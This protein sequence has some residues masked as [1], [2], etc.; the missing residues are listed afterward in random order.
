MEIN[1]LKNLISLKRLNGFGNIGILK[2]INSFPNILD[3]RINFTD[4]N[5]FLSPRLLNEF[6]NNFNKQFD[7]AG[8]LIELCQKKNIQ[9]NTFLDTNYPELLKHIP[10]APII[11]YTKGNLIPSPP[12]SIAIVGTRK[13]SE[14][15]D[16]Q[17]KR[18]TEFLAKQNYSIV[19]GLALGIDAISHITAINNNAHCI[20]VLGNGV[21]IP[22]PAINTRLY[23]KLLE[24]NGCIISEFEPGTEPRAEFF[25]SRNRIIAGLAKSTLVIEAAIKSGSLI[26][27]RQAFEY[28]RDVYALPADITRQNSQGCNL[29]IK[30]GVA[31]L[32]FDPNDIDTDYL[33]QIPQN[34]PLKQDSIHLDK[35][36]SNYR[37]VIEQLIIQSY[38]ADQLSEIINIPIPEL[39]PVLS[40]MELED[41]IKRSFEGKWSLNF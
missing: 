39:I 9:I 7:L 33:S 28:N 26:T 24:N 40:E 31:R 25:P 34:I 6:K 20:A 14:Y 27:A 23:E 5:R 22:Y 30:E 11:I 36:P 12:K 37:K 10:D 8:D 15:G 1:R 13:Y 2:L 17:T 4:V 41:L 16:I 21:D 32:T 3:S 38:T 35:L 19:S 29:L 18:Y